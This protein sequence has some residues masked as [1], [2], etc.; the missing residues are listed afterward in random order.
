[1]AMSELAA[2]QQISLG[3]SLRLSDYL[4]DRPHWSVKEMDARG[5]CKDYEQHAAANHTRGRQQKEERGQRFASTEG[6]TDPWRK[7]GFGELVSRVRR[8]RKVKRFQ[9]HDQAQDVP[10]S[11]DGELVELMIHLAVFPFFFGF[12]RGSRTPASVRRWLELESKP[13]P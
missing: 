3:F 4:C 5:D 9:Q 1:M 7:T 8:K 6:R 10:Q 13:R 2:P 11:G 12:F